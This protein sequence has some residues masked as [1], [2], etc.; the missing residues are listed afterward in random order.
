MLKKIKRNPLG[1]DFCVGDIHGHFS[2]LEQ[3][4]S[5]VSFDSSRD[6][7]F[8]VGDLVDK[9]PES[10]RADEFLAYPWFFSIRGN[11]EQ[12]VIEPHKYDER[13]VKENGGEWFLGLDESKK[14]Y[15]RQLFL[16]L[17]LAIEVETSIGQVGIIH[18]DV[19]LYDWA[20]LESKFYHPYWVETMLWSR[21]RFERNI[22][23]PVSN[24]EIVI[25][26][27]TPQPVIPARLGNVINIDGGVYKSD[28]ELGVYELTELNQ[29][30]G[31]REE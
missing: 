1:R 10:E 9:G 29:M 30:F 16:G 4:L 28:G 26:G 31:Y 17:P 2:V 21:S 23:Q 7:L 12:M 13:T 11:H 15:Y 27:H 5:E 20:Q 14:E 24:I 19:P 18:A 22:S 25:V 8:A 3:K 6:R